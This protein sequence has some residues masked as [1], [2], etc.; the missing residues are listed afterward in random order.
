MLFFLDGLKECLELLRQAQTEFDEK[1]STPLSNSQPVFLFFLTG[2]HVGKL[3]P[4]S[5]DGKR[6]HKSLRKD[7][8]GSS[9]YEIGFSDV[10]GRRNSMVR[11]PPFEPLTPQLNRLLC[12]KMT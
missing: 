11:S 12:R 7:E 10:L 9:R 6:Y 8:R 3:I 4:K 2:R 1:F 5:L